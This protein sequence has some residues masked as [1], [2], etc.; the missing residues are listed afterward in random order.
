MGIRDGVVVCVWVVVLCLEELENLCRHEKL[1]G[2][3]S[4]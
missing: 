1:M 3:A 2:F 4:L